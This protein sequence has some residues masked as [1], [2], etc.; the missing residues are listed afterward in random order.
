MGRRE[1][2]RIRKA[3]LQKKEFIENINRE[4]AK[5][6]YLG[7]DIDRFIKRLHR[8]IANYK[9]DAWL[10]GTKLL[11]LL[12]V[13]R[14]GRL[15]YRYIKKNLAP[16]TAKSVVN[17]ILVLNKYY[18]LPI[19][20]NTLKIAMAIW[21]DHSHNEIWESA[22]A[23]IIG[24]YGA[25]PNKRLNY[26]P[27][28]KKM[29]LEE[30]KFWGFIHINDFEDW[31]REA[32]HVYSNI[33]PNLVVPINFHDNS[34]HIR[35]KYPISIYIGRNLFDH[36]GGYTSLRIPEIKKTRTILSRNK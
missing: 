9:E 12:R 18:K 34:P 17:Y 31:D 3:N 26:I 27:K 13:N 20:L 16:E 14:D 21:Y 32:C 6:K 19:N 30:Q 29:I 5:E 35:E 28:D 10:I 23:R 24:G 15:V 22:K 33:D 7:G 36:I 8:S 4:T 1:Q 2:R 25:L 11:P